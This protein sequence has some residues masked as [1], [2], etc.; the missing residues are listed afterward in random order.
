MDEQLELEVRAALSRA[1]IQRNYRQ[2]HRT[3]Q[4]DV[5][6]ELKLDIRVMRVLLKLA[7][8]DRVLGEGLQPVV[9]EI[10]KLLSNA[11]GLTI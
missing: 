3:V 9:R 2:R 1:E 8:E 4:Q 5:V 11:A 10:S 7:R 6:A